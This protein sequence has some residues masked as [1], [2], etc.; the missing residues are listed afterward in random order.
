MGEPAQVETISVAIARPRAEVYALL[1]RPETYSDWA[2]GLGTD[3][4]YLGGMD[5]RAETPM[6]PMT[7][8]FTAPNPHGVLDHSLIADD[9]RETSNPMRVVANGDGSEV[10]FTLFRRPGLSDADFT[11]DADWVR[12]DLLALKG[13]LEG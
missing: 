12:R 3:F 8:R 9:G 1:S 6:G 13:L 7:I 5:W 2:S 11:H 10:S 4:Q